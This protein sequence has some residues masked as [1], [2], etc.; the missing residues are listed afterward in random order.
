[1][2]NNEQKWCA[3]SN[4][5]P[6]Q[7]GEELADI[8]GSWGIGIEVVI[9]RPFVYSQGPVRTILSAEKQID[10]TEGAR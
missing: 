1:M 4:P 9:T 6:K 7:L 5:Q 3:S 8:A 2:D 10:N